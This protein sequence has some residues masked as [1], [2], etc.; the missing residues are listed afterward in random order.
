[1]EAHRVNVLLHAI[2]FGLVTAAII[3]TSAVAFSL[4]YAVTDVPNFAHGELLTVAAY[5]AYETQQHG[6]GLAIGAAA[7]ATTGAA[8]AYLMYRLVLRGFVWKSSRL[9]YTVAVT[10]GISLIIQNGLGIL[11]GNAEVTLNLPSDQAR[12]VGPFLWTQTDITVIL[13]SLVALATVHLTLRHTPFGRAQRAVADN[14][15]LARA[16]GLRIERVISLTWLMAGAVAGL[17]GVALATSR[18]TF[19]PLLGNSFLLVTLAA[20]IVGGVGR[21][22]G[23]MIGALTIGLVTELSG[24]YFNAGY[25]QVAAL[26]VLTLVLL[27][28][29]SGILQVQRT[30]AEA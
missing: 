13:G 28:R 5:A 30:R 29:P 9:V 18:S 11:F 15:E 8:V 19:G 14:R 7:G 21:V 6:L 27:V 24:A 3:A 23:A 1:M 16:S 26:A 10:A 2:G 12:H 22:Y 25:K 20:A 17:G 4:Q